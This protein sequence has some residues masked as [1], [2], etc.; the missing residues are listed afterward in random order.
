MVAMGSV[1]ARVDLDALSKDLAAAYAPIV[2]SEASAIKYADL[3][4]AI[5]GT[6]VRHGMRLPREFVLVTKQMLYFDRYAKLL[7]PKLNVFRDPRIVSALAM[8]VMQARL[9]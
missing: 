1:D 2:S 4:P 5:M 6:A 7:A 8:D 3:I 9:A